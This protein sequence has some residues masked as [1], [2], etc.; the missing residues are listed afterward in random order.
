MEISIC[1]KRV[2]VHLL[3]VQ[4]KDDGNI[5]LPESISFKFFFKNNVSCEYLGK[6]ELNL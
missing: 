6:F 3:F 1:L 4:A 5:Q 2:N